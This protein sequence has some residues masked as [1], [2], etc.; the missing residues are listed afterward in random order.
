MITAASP[1][2]IA[3]EGWTYTYDELDRLT[4]ATNTS[5]ATYNQ[6]IAYDA[7]GNITSNSRLG[8]YTYGTRRKK[9]AVTAAGSNTYAYDAAGLMTSGAGRTHHLERR[10]PAGLGHQRR[11]H[12]RR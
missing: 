2:P 10:Q 6:T 12:H 11:R 1:S 7:I 8:A 3:N 9:H 5:S 4:A